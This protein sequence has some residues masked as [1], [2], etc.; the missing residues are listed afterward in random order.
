[1]RY[2]ASGVQLFSGAL[3][4]VSSAQRGESDFTQPTQPKNGT[5]LSGASWP[6]SQGTMEHG[7]VSVDDLGALVRSDAVVTV[8]DQ[9][10]R[11]LAPG[12]TGLEAVAL[13]HPERHVHVEA[14]HRTRGAA[15]VKHKAPLHGAAHRWGGGGHQRRRGVKLV[16]LPSV[17]KMPPPPP[18]QHTLMLVPTLILMVLL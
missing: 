1:M 5:T 15:L 10:G 11:A 4:V 16:V 2:G 7:G 9:A 6:A 17:Q 3:W 14:G 13:H 12:H 8:Q 18:T